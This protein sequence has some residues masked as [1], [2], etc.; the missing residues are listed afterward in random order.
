MKLFL[1]ALLLPFVG[2][3]TIEVKARGCYETPKG[4]VCVGYEGKAVTIDG[5][6]KGQ[7]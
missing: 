4:S 7:K 2:C 1:L 3:K 5:T 6:F